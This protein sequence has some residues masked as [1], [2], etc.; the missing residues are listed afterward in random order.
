MSTTLDPDRE[1]AAGETVT[2]EVMMD[3]KDAG[4]GKMMDRIVLIVNDPTR[5]LRELRL[6][7][8]IVD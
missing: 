3:T 2:F 6:A 8:T 7:A 5:P 4:T 1:I